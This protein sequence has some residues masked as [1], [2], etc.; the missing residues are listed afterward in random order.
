MEIA[1]IKNLIPEVIILVILIL[2]S[3]F[4]S[5]S[6]TA[7]TTLPRSK[8][9][10]FKQQK[11]R[12]VASLEVLIKQPGR[13]IAAILVGNNIVNILASVL[14]TVIM[15]SILGHMHWEEH[16]ALGSAITTGIMTFLILTFG[17]VS[18]KTIALAHRETLAPIVAPMVRLLVILFTPVII[19]LIS[20]PEM[21]MR[22]LRISKSPPG[23]SI[24]EQEVR[25]L[26]DASKDEGVIE[27]D[28]KKMLHKVFEFNDTPIRNAMTPRG[29]VQALDSDTPFEQVMKLFSA[30]P[31]SRVPVYRK[32]LD[33]ILGVLY[34]KDILLWV[35][36]GNRKKAQFA[37][38]GSALRKPLFVLETRTT[39]SVFRQM[40][41]E[42]NHFAVVVNSRGN[43][44]G[45]VTL[46]DLVEEIMGEI[47][48][49][50]EEEPKNTAR[51]T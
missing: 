33:N 13:M 31:F 10:L 20:F 29:K 21:V 12:G 8:L 47:E 26:I 24:T 28:E 43:L 46:E 17:E 1:V 2:L 22:V 4:F 11:R 16:L 51:S 19:F 37:N 18:P 49:E 9:K 34:A 7:L 25:A 45:I 40:K 50:F 14:G 27:E 32:K 6:E 5:A 39:A 30:K 3:A 41:R 23:Q 36:G 38:L 44:M 15:V 48:D 35:S 42:K